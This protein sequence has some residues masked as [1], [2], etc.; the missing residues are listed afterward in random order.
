MA[1]AALAAFGAVLATG[2]LDALTTEDALSSG[3]LWVF[4]SSVTLR[5]PARYKVE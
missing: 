2:L 4:M 3:F 5:R 1:A